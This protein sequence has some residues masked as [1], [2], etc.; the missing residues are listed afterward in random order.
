MIFDNAKNA[1]LYAAFPWIAEALGNADRYSDPDLAIGPYPIRDGLRAVV[2]RYESAPFEEGRYENHRDWIDLQYIV[3]G[4]E[5]IEVVPASRGT[6]VREYDPAADY[7]MYASDR[8]RASVLHMRPGDFA[9]LF[10]GEAHYP[11]LADGQPSNV[12]KIVI[13]IKA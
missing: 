8:S 3:S 7:E 11:G 5:L 12:H 10:P 6:P 1:G 13:K 9:V 4:E 2:N